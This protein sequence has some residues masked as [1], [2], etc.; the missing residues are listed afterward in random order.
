MAKLVLV[1][2]G[3]S[4]WNALNLFNGWVDTPLSDRGRLEIQDTALS[5][6]DAQIHFDYAYTS[7]LTRAIES[8]NLLLQW[9]NAEYIPV[10]KSWRLNERHYG[11]LQG[12][13]KLEAVNQWGEKQVKAW[14]RSYDVQPPL[15]SEYQ[16]VIEVEG[17]EYP[18]FDQR[19]A[20]VKFG[21]LP[22]GESLMMTVDRVLPLWFNE[23]SD[24]L[25]KDQNILIVAHGNS[26]RAFRK[27]LEKLDDS[28][29]SELEIKNGEAVVYDF[30][31]M[32]SIVDKRIIRN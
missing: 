14:R 19:Y 7:M 24:R 5:L 6:K 26:I 29:I 10:I 12:M 16:Q 2:H 30:D 8:T 21:N 27:Y 18:L 4:T 13:N 25:S 20:D 17:Q 32:L 3:E 28:E 1:R 31:N 22:L 15:D 23:I 11:S 9:I